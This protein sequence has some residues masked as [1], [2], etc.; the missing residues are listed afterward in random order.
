MS[1][2]IFKKKKPLKK[3]FYF[4]HLVLRGRMIHSERKQLEE[5]GG[6]SLHYMKRKIL[7]AFF[8]EK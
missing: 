2:K 3:W 4:S 1:K 6:V 8:D 7:F 5:K